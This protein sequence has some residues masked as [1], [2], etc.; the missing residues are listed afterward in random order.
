MGTTGRGFTLRLLSTHG[1]LRRPWPRCVCSEYPRVDRGRDASLRNIHAAAAA[2]PRPVREGP[3]R[4]K[5]SVPKK[6]RAGPDW[7]KAKA[8]GGPGS[9]YQRLR[10]TID[11]GKLNTVCDEAACPNAGECWEG[12][13]RGRAE[14]LVLASFF[15]EEDASGVASSFKRTTFTGLLALSFEKTPPAARMIR[16]RS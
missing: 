14:F 6:E 9:R 7:F 3:A 5:R 8:P 1:Y 10:E 15:E 16:R 12:G 4:R 11:A 2:A 13:P